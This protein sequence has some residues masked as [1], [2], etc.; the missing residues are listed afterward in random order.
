MGKERG[1]RGRIG[2][3]GVRGEGEVGR[4]M[5]EGEMQITAHA[6]SQ[7]SFL[8]MNFYL[9]VRYATDPLNWRMLYSC[10]AS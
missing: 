10:V 2:D 5:A 8:F 7:L 4:G 9:L 3:M 6:I 1:G